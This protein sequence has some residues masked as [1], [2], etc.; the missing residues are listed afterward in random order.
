M[1]SEISI[2]CFLVLAET[3]NFS[4]TARRVYLTQ[5]AVSKNISG[6]ENSLGFLLFKRSTRE[7][8]LTAEGLECVELFKNISDMYSKKVNELRSAYVRKASVINVGYQDFLELGVA[9]LRANRS[10]EQDYPDAQIA[11]MRYA[12]GMLIELFL[13]K[14]LDIIITSSRFVPAGENINSQPLLRIPSVIMVSP[15]NPNV[16]EDATYLDFKNE[17]Y[18]ADKFEYESQEAFDKRINRELEMCELTPAKI[19]A[20]PNRGAVYS[21]A[22]AGE[23]I[24]LGSEISQISRGS[25]LM[26][27]R[28]GTVEYISCVWQKKE[29]N[30]M[31]RK[32]VEHLKKAYGNDFHTVF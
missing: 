27:Y 8:N 29:P 3:L 1:I 23:G 18:L 21:S 4:E 12:P 28:T 16:S 6:L 22:E 24:L 20:L 10:M 17:P 11:G 25:N 14:R 31:V 7:V 32:Y 26:R 30:V 2:K 15:D 5:Q 9:L 19:L 13:E